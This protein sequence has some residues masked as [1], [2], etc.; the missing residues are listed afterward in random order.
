[1]LIACEQSL[2]RENVRRMRRRLTR[3]N[4][5]GCRAT[6]RKE[7]DICSGVCM[8]GANQF[9]A[10]HG[11]RLHQRANMSSPPAGSYIWLACTRRLPWRTVAFLADARKR[12]VLRQVGAAYEFCHIRLLERLAKQPHQHHKR[13]SGQLHGPASRPE[14]RSGSY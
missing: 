5:A 14:H 4:V 12:S 7:S 13:G 9:L 2:L 8:L 3:L 10:N 6:S 11:Q 1:M